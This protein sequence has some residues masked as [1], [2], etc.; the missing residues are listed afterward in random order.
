MVPYTGTLGIQVRE[1]RPGYARIELPDRRRVRNHLSSIHAVALTNLGE[2][3][4][5]LAMLLALPPGVRAIVLGLSSEYHK[6]AR[7]R[8]VAESSP[9][10]PPAV[11]VDTEHTVEAL[12]RDAAGDVVSRTTVRWRLSP[13]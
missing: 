12:V 2:V 10:P 5:G 3:T 9:T 8:L 7:G 13:A 1:L 4:S 6:K 11:P